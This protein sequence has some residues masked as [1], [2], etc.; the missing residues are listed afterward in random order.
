[1]T[2]FYRQLICDA[3]YG[4]HN[5]LF[6]IFLPFPPVFAIEERRTCAYLLPVLA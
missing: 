5:E 1:V 6:L 2:I 3:R 4:L